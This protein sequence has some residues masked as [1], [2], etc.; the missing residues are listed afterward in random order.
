LLVAVLVASAV[1][2][3]LPLGRRPFDN[4][5]EARYSLL[6][7]EAVERGHWVLPRGG[8]GG[9]LKKPPLYFWAVAVVALPFGT[10]RDARA[11][12]AAVV[13]AVVGLG[14]VFAIG[15][16]LWGSGAGLAAVVILAT[17][18]FYFFMAHQVLTDMMLTAWLSWGLYFYL[19]AGRTRYAMKPLVAF[20]LCTA[21]GLASKGPAALMVVLAALVAT[22]VADGW[23]RIRG[24][25]LPL[26]LGLIVL[27]A[28]PWILLYVLQ[29]ERSYGRS[30]VMKEYVLWY[31]ASSV[32]SR[33]GALL[34]HFGRFL[35]WGFFL[36]PAA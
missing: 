30:V 32:A 26:G 28:L 10:G 11:P 14:A 5:D 2:F 19:A 36:L 24:R 7:R 31:F 16:L 12:I 22:V 27:T 15:R 1:I 34:S 20:Y 35:P 18:P 23:R 33:L 17:S 29:G 4:Q 8:E 25:R 21:G 9:D 6:A 13:A 3:A